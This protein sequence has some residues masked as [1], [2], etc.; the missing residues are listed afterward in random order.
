MYCIVVTVAVFDPE[1][2]SYLDDCNDC[3]GCCSPAG[4]T[5]RVALQ[6]VAAP[7]C[8]SVR[9]CGAGAGPSRRQVGTS[10]FRGGPLDPT[11]AAV[12]DAVDGRRGCDVALL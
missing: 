3:I 11:V 12:C 5:S 2:F 10:G 4:P 6:G 9:S 7:R 8:C 1:L